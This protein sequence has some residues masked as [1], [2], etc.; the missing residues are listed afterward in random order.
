[1]PDLLDMIADV[2]RHYPIDAGF[3]RTDTSRE[4]AQ[5]IDAGTLRAK[6][7]DAIRAHGPL[8]A[9]EAAERLRLDKLSIRPRLS[10]LR[11][12]GKVADTGER[13]SNASGRR[14]IVWRLAA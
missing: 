12:H 5:R 1:M 9:D 10:E 11:A 2:E 13:R 14:A 6:V 7:L 3:K 4:A 8:T